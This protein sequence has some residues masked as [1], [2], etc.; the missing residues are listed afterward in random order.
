MKMKKILSMALCLLI[1]C[2]VCPIVLADEAPVELASAEDLLQLGTNPDG[3]YI[4]TRD[5][6]MG[7][8]IWVPA[9]FS[10]T[11]DGNGHT[12]YNLSVYTV[13]MTH[14]DTVDGN[15]KVYDSEFAGLFS[16]LDGAAVKNLKLRGVDVRVESEGH[17]FVVSIA[18]YA[19]NSTLENCSVYK[20]G[21]AHV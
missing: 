21:R 3:S 4:L 6:D 12:I 1:L 16:V 10:G 11:L 13:G 14:R 8:V 15:D 9:A 20:I 19:K 2:S 18:G 17:C 7:D 5:I